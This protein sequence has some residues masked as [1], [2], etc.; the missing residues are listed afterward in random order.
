MDRPYVQH[1]RI[2]KY[3]CIEDLTLKLTPLHALIGPN[4]SGK[5]TVL[6]AVRTLT[7]LA[8][9]PLGAADD[10]GKLHAALGTNPE[11]AIEGAP[12][13]GKGWRIARHGGPAGQVYEEALPDTAYAQREVLNV[14]T[15]HRMFLQQNSV[16][17]LALGGSIL[18][19]LEP[20]ALRAP[21]NLIPEG[22]PLRFQNALGQ[23]LPAVYDAIISRDIAAYTSINQQ[24]MTLYPTIKSLS[25]K[26]PTQSTKAIGVQLQDG[27]WVGADF[28]SE[29]MLY[30][31]AFAALPHLTPAAMILI[32]E[33]ENGLHPAR[34]REV[35][36]VLRE[37]SKTTQVLLAT[38]SPLVI[39]ELQPEEVTV[40]TRKPEEGT[41]G[42]LM[43]ETPNFEERSKVY[44]LG[45]LWVSY[46]DGDFEAPL[47][48]EPEPTPPPGEPVEWSESDGR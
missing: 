6:M 17:R 42:R 2:Q 27:H 12:D 23:G 13:G 31:L 30:Y 34:V 10:S 33:P 44:A 19:R 15:S 32:E 26:N 18:L 5:S 4:D 46:A 36:R 29:G 16:P 9:G 1:L 35:M 37:I 20:D 47:F 21:T 14:N 48:K 11:F 22:Q 45:E 43:K 38:H 41:K 39:N 8:A 3:G 24:L 7:T 40:L 25:L 28:M